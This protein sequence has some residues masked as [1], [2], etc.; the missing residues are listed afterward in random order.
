MFRPFMRGISRIEFASPAL[1]LARESYVYQIIE[2]E[3]ERQLESLGAQRLPS[4][5]VVT[6]PAKPAP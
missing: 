2:G 6:G 4:E 1:V 5:A 3:W